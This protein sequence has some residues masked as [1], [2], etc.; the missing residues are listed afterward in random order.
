MLSPV[1]HVPS[2]DAFLVT[3][4][5]SHFTSAAS[6]EEA[7][8]AQQTP[9]PVA[10]TASACRRTMRGSVA[11]AHGSDAGCFCP[12]R[13][14]GWRISKWGGAAQTARPVAPEGELRCA[15]HATRATRRRFTFGA[16]HPTEGTDDGNHHSAS[17][18][19]RRR[20]DETGRALM[21]TN[22]ER[23]RHPGIYKR[24]SKYVITWRHHGKQHKQS[25]RT[26]E[27]ARAE[28]GRR[29]AGDRAALSRVRFEDYASDWL[30]AYQGR[31]SRGFSERTRAAY[32]TAFAMYVIPYFCRYRLAEVEPQTVR[33]FVNEMGA[34][35][36]GQRRSEESLPRS[37]RCTP[38]HSRTAWCRSTQRQGFGSIS[39]VSSLPRVKFA[40][41][42][43][44]SSATF[45]EQ[46]P[47]NGGSSSSSSPTP[48]LGSRRRSD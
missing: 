11:A 14:V 26:L 13:G 18:Q 3:D 37:G 41:L 47:E 8:P 29:D 15:A 34:T 7:A 42:L 17:T 45:S 48:A 4:F 38:T 22:M 6:A 24:G 20:Q 43:A 39:V 32:R 31:T 9:K 23:T 16:V 21:A 44:K 1:P 5:C 28:K 46:P 10:T 12:S 40:R 19:S 2:T 33:A 27:E 25:F 35:N 36:L 30:D